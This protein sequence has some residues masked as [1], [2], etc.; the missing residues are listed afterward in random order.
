MQIKY[1]RLK[2]G[3]AFQWFKD[4]AVFVRCPGGFRPARGGKLHTL[5]SLNPNSIVYLYPGE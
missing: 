2:T 3:D 1:Y 4:G 5:M